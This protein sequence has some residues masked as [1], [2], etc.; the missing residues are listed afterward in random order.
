MGYYLK[1]F[2]D[3]GNIQNSNLKD[4]D[5]KTELK[6]VTKIRLFKLRRKL[7]RRDIAHDLFRR[8]LF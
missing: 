8:Q 3:H 6:G 2:I 1:N 7:S 5:A 4:R